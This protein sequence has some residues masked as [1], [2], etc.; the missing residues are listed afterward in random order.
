[1]ETRNPL[2][3]LPLFICLSL[4]ACQPSQPGLD[5]TSTHESL[6]TSAS[7]TAQAHFTTAA[8]IPG[9]LATSTPTLVPSPTSTYT[10]VPTSTITPTPT[11]LAISV[12]NA[13]Q[14][15]L[16]DMLIDI[17]EVDGIIFSPGEVATLRFMNDNTLQKDIL[18]L[19]VPLPDFG[20][21]PWTF[22]SPAFSSDGKMVVSQTQD[23]NGYALTIWEVR[24]DLR[25]RP[26]ARDISGYSYQGFY[27]GFSGDGKLLTSVSIPFIMHVYMDADQWRKCEPHCDIP[28]T[29]AP[30]SSGVYQLPEGSQVSNLAITSVDSFEYKVDFSPGNDFLATVSHRTD[31]NMNVLQYIQ[32]WQVS[33]GALYR[34]LDPL[35]YEGHNGEQANP[36]FSP[37]GEDLAIICSAK[38]QVWQWEPNTFHWMV[39]GIFSALAYSPDGI[40]IATGAPDGSISLWRASDGVELA[41][42]SAKD[43]PISY[44]AFS[45]DGSLLVTLDARGVLTLWSVSK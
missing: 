34:Y 23:E 1:M 5:V 10:P 45:P 22:A 35:R 13:A 28:I 32:L 2:V 7:Q 41:T 42:L 12:E 26:L 8:T 30:V 6:N 37:T 20:P 44:V 4:V 25:L 21:T 9:P 18:Q 17:G 19:H 33:D 40:L 43:H 11:P 16:L 24:E 31:S 36:A 39:D 14:L 27:Y 3:L 38:L 15:T 29:F